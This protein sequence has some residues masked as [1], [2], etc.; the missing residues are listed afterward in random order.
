VEA[1]QEI[2]TP[3]QVSELNNEATKHFNRKVGASA[4]CFQKVLNC[5]QNWRLI[6]LFSL[7]VHRREIAAKEKAVHLAM[8]VFSQSF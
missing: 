6:I 5:I 7:S 8:K 1:G 4:N 3:K 2:K